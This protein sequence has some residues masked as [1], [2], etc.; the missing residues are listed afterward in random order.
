[1][2]AFKLLVFTNPVEGR[3]DEYNDWYDN[4]HVPD[5]MTFDGWKS[6][7][8]FKTGPRYLGRDAPA[9]YVA[10]YEIEADSIEEVLRASDEGTAD[11]FITDA[12]DLESAWA[13][14]LTPIGPLVRRDDRAADH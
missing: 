8:R 11:T 14:P 4:Q 10:I 7:Q 2:P 3:D 1:M 5:T 9:R 13:I 12:L 6:A